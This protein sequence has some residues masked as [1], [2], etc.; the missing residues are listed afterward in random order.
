MLKINTSGD[1]TDQYLA[2][3]NGQIIGLVDKSV[4]S[5]KSLEKLQ[6]NVL[7]QALNMV[8][9]NLNNK[10]LNL[11][12]AVVR[13]DISGGKVDFP[14]GIAVD[15][16]DFYLV[17]DGKLNLQND[18]INFEL[19]PFS[20]KITDVNISNVLGGLV[21]VS[22]TVKNPKLGLNQTET[23]KNVIGILAS[24]GAYNVGDMML[25]SDSAPCHTALAGTAYAS[26][27]PED[28]TVTGVASKGYTNTKDAIKGLGKE[29]KD[30]AKGVKNQVKDIG[31]Q[32]KGLF[33]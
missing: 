28:K 27:F 10:N 24:G 16:S 7:V 13:G 32:L 8:N 4:L 31:K 23:A 5:V 6:G 30:Q 11:K 21:K 18:K 9:I 26:Y 14:K 2:N 3:M 12:C 29:I 17:A 19:K 25:S 1:N 22:G 20:G 33:K 15:A